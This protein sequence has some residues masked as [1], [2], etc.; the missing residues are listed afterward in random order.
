MYSR[1]I[2]NRGLVLI[3]VIVGVG[4]MTLAF[5]SIFGAFQLSVEVIT[6]SKARIGALALAQGQIE[7]VRS[8]S[9]DEVGTLGGIPSG[10]ILQNEIITLNGIAYTQ[11]TLIQNVDDP[12]DGIG[13]LDENSVTA[14]YKRVK[15]EVSW[16]IRGDT[17]SLSLVTS[18]VPKGIETLAGGGTLIINVFDA[19]GVAVSGANVHI[20]NNELDPTVSVDISTNAQGKVSFPGSP[21]G[22]DYEVTVSKAGYS[23]TQ[24][25][26]TTAE[27][28]NPNPGHLSVIEGETT[29][30]SFAIDIVGT[31]T[32]RTFSPIGDNAW[33]D[34]FDNTLNL[35]AQTNTTVS[36]GALALT[37]PGSGYELNGS[38][39]SVDIAP[40]YLAAWQEVQWEDT[41]PADTSILYRLYY[42]EGGTTLAPIPDV[43]LPGN[44]VG[45]TSS[46]LDISALPIGAYDTIQIAGFLSTADASTTPAISE[47]E[48]K[49]SSGPTPISNLPFHM[50]GSKTIGIDSDEDPIYKYDT[51][52]QTGGDGTVAIPDLEWDNY[53]ITIDNTGIGSDISEICTPQPRSLNPG[54]NVTTDMFLV[55]VSSHS[56]LV[57]VTD[58]GGVLLEGASARLYKSGYDTTQDTSSCGQ[59]FF[60]ALSPASDYEID[61]TLSGY[62]PVTVSNIDVTGAS[63]IIIVLE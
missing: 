54:E 6:H 9:Y 34:E 8:L 12:K 21:S 28:P 39:Y 27:N 1:H 33:E 38:A 32:V 57:A 42:Y 23:S 44:G 52:L 55:P 15:V 50:R 25:Y 41:I 48:V 14:D 20:E 61:V 62:T 24:T 3:D 56:L 58:T 13:V 45:F 11:R 49:Y 47:W 30:V 43:D 4:L 51:D 31:K 22:N 10:N 63:N 16:E 17:K 35:S 2:H 36:G 29:S 53:I 59:T 19:L 37:D 7:G 46:P 26:D 60:S 5:F 18:I 40:E